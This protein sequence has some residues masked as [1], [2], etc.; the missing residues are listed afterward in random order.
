MALLNF[1]LNKDIHPTVEGIFVADDVEIDLVLNWYE[2][3]GNNLIGE[4]PILGISVKNILELFEA[5]F[6]NGV[7]HCWSVE[8]KHIATLNALVSHEINPQKHAYFVEI[9]KKRNIED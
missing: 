3:K 2:I 1:K 4:E 7:Y 6:W 8:S 9:Y 5:P